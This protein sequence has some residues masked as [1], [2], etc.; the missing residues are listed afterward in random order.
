[1]KKLLLDQ[2]LQTQIEKTQESKVMFFTCTQKCVFHRHRLQLSGGRS[3]FIYLLWSSSMQRKKNG[4]Q[5]KKN[6]YKS[7][8]L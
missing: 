4:E 7:F 5:L 2:K 8:E 6:D 1:M 3:H